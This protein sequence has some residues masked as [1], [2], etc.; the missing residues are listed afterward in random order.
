MFTVLGAAGAY[1]IARQGLRPVQ[2]LSHLVRQI[3]A[4][5]LDHR[6]ALNG[7]PDEVQA[8]ADAFD[9][10]LE[11]LERAFD[12]QGRFV[13]DAAHELRTPLAT[14]RTNLE[15]IRQD[16]DATLS[17]YQEMTQA[18]DRA[19]GRLE[20]LVE[21]LLLLARGAK[22]VWR[23]PTSLDVLLAD[24]IDEVVPLA[25]SHQVTVKLEIVD[26]LLVL[27][28]APLL[29][30][31]LG[32]LIE[33]GI[34]YNRPGGSVTIRV[35]RE[36][37]GAVMRV[38]DTGVGIPPGDLAHIFERF[39]RGDRSRARHW[40]GAGLGLSITA[41]IVQLHG[42]HIGVES[43]PGVGSVFSVWLPCQER[44]S[45]STQT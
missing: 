42:G 4:E 38:E 11:R 35:W 9:E 8:L 24:V 13:A 22:E 20:A 12:Q 27:G 26:E 36:A 14:L 40:G 17:D 34:R 39:Y 3:Q 37:A 16:P 28:E 23:E 5:S 15:V 33:N 43:T 6:L 19:L 18:L 32:N 45:H 21:D 44:E 41:H 29:A 10:M 25:Q 1:W 30:R 7:P 2:H 31:A